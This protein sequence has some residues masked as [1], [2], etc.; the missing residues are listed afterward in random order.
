MNDPHRPNPSA[1]AQLERIMQE[2]QHL[3]AHPRIQQKTWVARAKEWLPLLGIIRSE[4]IGQPESAV[5]ASSAASPAQDD[6]A[7][8]VEV[9][10]EH[11]KT[12]IS[13][14]L[15]DVQQVTV[16]RGDE[17]GYARVRGAHSGFTLKDGRKFL[18]RADEAQ[19]IVDALRRRDEMSTDNPSAP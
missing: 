13:V 18:T 6:G 11:S 1:V 14:N 7:I 10:T 3:V 5:P 8:L 17:P 15:S 12:F 2:M 19:R 9:N 4:L 16:Y